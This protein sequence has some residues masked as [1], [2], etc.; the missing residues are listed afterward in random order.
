ML[1]NSTIAVIVVVLLILIFLI[2]AD[3]I[4]WNGL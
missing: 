1:G 4:Q 2:V 3:V